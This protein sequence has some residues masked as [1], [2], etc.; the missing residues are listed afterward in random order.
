M[1]QL[2]TRD[3]NA[4]SE[5]E[6]VVPHGKKGQGIRMK[7]NCGR[8][9]GTGHYSFNLMDGTRC[10]GC[11]GGKFK[12][13]IVPV[14]TAE[15]LAKLEE[16]DGKRRAAKKR[17]NDAKA[18]EARAKAD[19]ALEAFMAVHGALVGRAQAISGNEFVTDI[20]AKLA[21]YGSL[22]DKQVAALQGAV[23]REEVKARQDATRRDGVGVVG[24]EITDCGKVVFRDVQPG[25]AYGTT[26][27]FMIIKHDDGTVFSYRGTGELSDLGRGDTVTF[28]AKVKD[29]R[30]NS[31]GETVTVLLR[32]KIIA[33][34]PAS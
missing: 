1:A 13:E 10:Y 6:K 30:K 19:A 22:S 17:L 31:R 7:V 21:Q 8:C 2:F 3:G 29:H 14:Y 20:L 12:M 24:E 16:A 9:G 18:A 27:V 33:L 26:T 34:T 11:D 15:K 23:E 28:R 25:F 5:F 4:V 32:P